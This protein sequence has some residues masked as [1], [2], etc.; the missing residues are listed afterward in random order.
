MSTPKHIGIRRNTVVW[1]SDFQAIFDGEGGI[2]ASQSFKCHSADA[3]RLLPP[4]GSPCQE[5]GFSSL[6]LDSARM[7]IEDGHIGVVR[8]TYGGTTNT[9]DFTF[10]S[11]TGA[12]TGEASR[13]T[14]LLVSTA[15]SPLA[16][17]P[18]YGLFTASPDVSAA[19]L[20][21][22]NA[23]EIVPEIEDPDTSNPTTKWKLIKDDEKVDIELSDKEKELFEYLTNDITTFMDPTLEWEVS[24]SSGHPITN[25]QLNAFGTIVNPPDH[26]P[27]PSGRN[28]LFS[29]ATQEET[30]GVYSI[31]LVFT[32]SGRGGWI[33]DLYKKTNV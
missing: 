1:Q 18:R 15:D 11:G 19:K 29:N 25:A 31:T 8:C 23:G 22:F 9:E 13:R 24:Y 4:K 12:V 17:H 5:P 16:A 2:S 26:P 32:L 3:L 6:L 27:T 14:R 28:W 10:D 7:E 20:L 21:Q 30:G 33:E